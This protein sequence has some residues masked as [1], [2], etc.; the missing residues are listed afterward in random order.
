M[1]QSTNRLGKSSY[2]S[3]I[4]FSIAVLSSFALQ[5]GFSVYPRV[6]IRGQRSRSRSN[7]F[8]MDPAEGDRARLAAAQA[9]RERIQARNIKRAAAEQRARDDRAARLLQLQQI[10][11]TGA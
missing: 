6:A 2:T 10:A 5:E 1:S 9:K 8:P 11:K 3:S 7:T 4:L